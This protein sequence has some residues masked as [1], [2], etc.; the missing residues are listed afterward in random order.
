MRIRRC[1]HNLD[2]HLIVDNDATH[3]HPKVRV[4]L[5]KHTL[6]HALHADVFSRHSLMFSFA[7]API[8]LFM[9]SYPC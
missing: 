2:V 3:K 8:S 7:H 4:W 5:A 1:P 6:P 9:A